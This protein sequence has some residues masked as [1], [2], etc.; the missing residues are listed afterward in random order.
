MMQVALGGGSIGWDSVKAKLEKTDPDLIKIIEATF[1]V[2]PS[3]GGV[4]L[5]PNWGERHG[6]RI[7]PFRFEVVNRKTQKQCVLVIEESDDFEF[8][9]RFKFTWEWSQ[10]A[11]QAEQPG[12][13]QSAT[14]TADKSPV[15]GQPSP[16][17]GSPKNASASQPPAGMITAIRE[18][19]AWRFRVRVGTSG[20]NTSTSVKVTLNGKDIPSSLCTREPDSIFGLNESYMNVSLS[21]EIVKTGVLELSDSHR[22]SSGD[23]GTTR[24][25]IPLADLTK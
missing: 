1:I 2:S 22:H 15:E 11:D 13:S 19:G 5:G 23:E 12:V 21:D 3:G 17:S 18:N 16:S 4:R 8:T 25:T 24:Y 7:A 9:G 14:K 10:K 20:Y 6:D